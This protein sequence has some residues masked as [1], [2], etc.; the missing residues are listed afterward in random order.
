MK[1]TLIAFGALLMIVALAACGNSSSK[2]TVKTQLGTSKLSIV[3]PE[4]FV[5]TE[6]DFGED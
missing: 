2:E 4:G 5:A 3:L 6:D 1:K